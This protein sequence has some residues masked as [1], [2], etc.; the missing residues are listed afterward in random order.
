MNGEHVEML[1]DVFVAVWEYYPTGQD[2]F[3][4]ECHPYTSLELHFFFIQ[5]G[6]EEC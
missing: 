5:D 4:T 2:E 6:H 3:Q 1:R